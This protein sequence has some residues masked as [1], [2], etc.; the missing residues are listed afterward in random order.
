ME[1]KLPQYAVIP[2]GI[3]FVVAGAALLFCGLPMSIGKGSIT[4]PTKA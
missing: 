4:F 1:K 3:A 2:L